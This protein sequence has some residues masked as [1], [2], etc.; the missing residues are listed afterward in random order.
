M[1]DGDRFDAGGRL[2]LAD[3]IWKRLYGCY[4]ELDVPAELRRLAAN[5]D[6][7]RAGTLFFDE[8]H[9]Q[10]MLF[11]ATW[12]AF[13]WIWRIAERDEDARASCLGFLSHVVYCAAEDDGT[14]APRSLSGLA[15]DPAEH[16][17]ASRPPGRRPGPEDGPVLER[18]AEA[19]LALIPALDAACIASVEDDPMT[20][21]FLL[22]GP[23]AIRGVPQASS[24]LE[25]EGTGEGWRA[26]VGQMGW[27]PGR[28]QKEALTGLARSVQPRAPGVARVLREVAG[29]SS[30]N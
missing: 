20:A 6:E 1:T 10:E 29:G 30:L 19:A 4:G 27:I 7:D 28:R 12:A 18:I 24:A 16:A 5:W 8:L 15:L 14:I 23:L 13:P 9:H 22:S 26:I 11:P 17:R 21:A 25:W 2:D 3:P